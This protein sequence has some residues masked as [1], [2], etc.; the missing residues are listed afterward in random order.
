MYEAPFQSLEEG[1]SFLITQYEKYINKSTQGSGTD[2]AQAL[3]YRDDLQS[4]LENNSDIPPEIVSRIFSLDHKLK[5]LVP[6]L[7]VKLDQS[8][9]AMMK[10]TYP[11]SH[12]WWHAEGG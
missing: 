12:W 2:L 4:A 5:T 3:N 11:E 9:A 1:L 6:E 7:R 8:F 10:K